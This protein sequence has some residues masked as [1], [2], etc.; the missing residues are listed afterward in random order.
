MS[1][2]QAYIYTLHF[3]EILGGRAYHYSGC[4]HDLRSRLVRHANGHGS[5]MTRHLWE[6]GR[7]WH[8]G[9]LQV[10]SHAAM[11][12]VERHLKDQH[13]A[14]RYCEICTQGKAQRLTDAQ[15]YP[16]ALCPFP[17]SSQALRLSDRSMIRD[18]R[19]SITVRLTTDHEPK[20]TQAFIRLVMDQDKDALGFVPVGGASGIHKQI[21]RGLVAIVANNDQDVGYALFSFSPGTIQLLNIHQCAIADDARLCGHGR[22][23]VG[24]LA[25]LFP[26]AHMGCKVRNDLAANH[27][28]LALGFEEGRESYHATSGSRINVYKRKPLR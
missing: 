4:T 19:D 5:A 1:I 9:G 23:L 16:I 13:Q 15:Q 17:T 2:R 22:A 3:D 24:Y 6:E 12:R 14:G 8:L 27:F 10:C 26:H 11:R 25:G 28:W 7:G 20:T 21:A 18:L